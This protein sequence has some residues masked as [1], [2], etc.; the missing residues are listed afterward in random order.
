MSS[1]MFSP[2]LV[3]TWK[4]FVIDLANFSKLKKVFS[5]LKKVACSW[6]SSWAIGQVT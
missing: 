4:N 1:S 3:S 6:S 5:K 2:I